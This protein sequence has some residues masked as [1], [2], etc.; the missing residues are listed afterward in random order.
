MAK[1]I[2]VEDDINLANIYISSI[3]ALRGSSDIEYW[4]EPGGE[5]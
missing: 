4:Q 1:I 3:P 2:I 5:K